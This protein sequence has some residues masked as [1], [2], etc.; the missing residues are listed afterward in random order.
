MSKKLHLIVVGN[1]CTGRKMKYWHKYKYNKKAQS[2][3]LR[4]EMSDSRKLQY[5]REDFFTPQGTTVLVAQKNISASCR[6]T[7][8][9]K[10]QHTVLRT[11]YCTTGSTLARIRTSTKGTVSRFSETYLF[12]NYC[13]YKLC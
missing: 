8:C 10:V 1:S 2:E 13:T 5:R 6:K 7:A 11:P 12:R 3:I 9:R 4:S